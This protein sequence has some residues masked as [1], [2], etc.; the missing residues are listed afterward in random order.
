MKDALDLYCIVKI[1][2]QSLWGESHEN[3]SL[4][5]TSAE[6]MIVLLIHHLFPSSGVLVLAT[7][8]RR[9]LTF[10]GGVTSPRVGDV[11]VRSHTGALEFCIWFDI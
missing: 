10:F 8:Q 3:R 7:D 9:F 5:Q 6:S 4:V 1:A 2:I 11:R